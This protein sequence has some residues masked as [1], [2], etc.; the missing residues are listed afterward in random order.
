[1][2]RQSAKGSDLPTVIAVAVVASASSVVHELI[3]HGAGCLL[4]GVE[5]VL[6][7]SI[8]LQSAGGNRIVDV[9]GPVA[10]ILV[11]AVA[12]YLFRRQ[13]KFTAFSFF[14][15]LFAAT[16][17]LVATG[18]LFYSGLT[19]WGDWASVIRGLRPQYAWRATISIAGI[20]LYIGVVRLLCRSMITLVKEGEVRLSDVRRLIFPAYLT[21]GLLAVASAA[22]NPVSPRLIWVNGFSG[23]FLAFLGLLRIPSIVDQY[24]TETHEGKAIPFSPTWTAFAVIVAILFIFVLGRGIRL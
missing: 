22:F 12:F 21:C 13:P 7:S 14:L 3:G 20:V 24:T 8:I 18:Y 10:N 2:P 19:N 4:T 16:N 6:V 1:M 15:W 17:L 11:G 23:S 9:G 5:P